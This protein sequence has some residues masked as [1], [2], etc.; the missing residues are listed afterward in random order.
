M[1]SEQMRRV[2][3]PII[4]NNTV[5]EPHSKCLVSHTTT[6]RISRP[7]SLIITDIAKE[8]LDVE[9]TADDIEA[10]HCHCRDSMKATNLHHHPALF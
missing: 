5:D 7:L 9:V 3:K 4:M 2:L 8:K 6:M 1:N 10:C